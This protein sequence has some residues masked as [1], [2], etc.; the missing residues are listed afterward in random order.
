DAY[1]SAR[2]ALDELGL[3]PSA[4]LQQIERAI[5]NHDDAIAVPAEQERLVR[6]RVPAPLTPLLGR[7]A[8]L[9]DVVRSLE[10]QNVRLLTLTGPGGTA[11]TRLALE[12]LH[13]D[14]AHYAYGAVFVPLAPVT[15][16]DHVVSTIAKWVGVR[17]TGTEALDVTL[18]RQLSDSRMLLV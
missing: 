7:R 1:R 5:L 18:V 2:A 3:E 10:D 13:T 12:A 6:P 11:K 8:E 4:E 16:V 15:N 17:E 14:A 9:A